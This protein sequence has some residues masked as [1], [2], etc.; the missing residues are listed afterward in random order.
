MKYLIL[1]LVLSPAAY[2]NS[3]RIKSILEQ[4]PTCQNFIRFDEKNLYLGFGAYRNNL[5]DPRLPRPATMQV[6]P[7]DGSPAFSLATN[8]S[9]IDLLS[10]EDHAFVLTHSSLEE[11]DLRSRERVAEHR[12]HDQEGLLR[13]REHAEAFA[14]YKDIAIIAHGRLGISF[15]DLKARR[16]LGTTR[17]I[18]SQYPLESMATSVTVQGKFAY[19]LMDGYTLVPPNQK[20]PF[21]GLVVVDM[22]NYSMVE[23]GGMDP[24]ADAITSDAQKVIV[25]FGGIP[26]WKYNLAKLQGKSLPEPEARFS[27]YPLADWP[28]GSP[29]MDANYYY[30]CFRKSEGRGSY[31]RQ[32][33]A[34][35]RKEWRLD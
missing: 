14:R 28:T 21:R 12:T 10:T 18:K 19:V 25:S 15:F 31:T 9:A 11:W 3:E 20:P 13:F 35:D 30:T 26:I 29:A 7:L 6:A 1:A 2:A 4:Q 24:G 17:L 27:S 32:P 5:E 8:D 16:F 23:L 34:L 22:E 33:M